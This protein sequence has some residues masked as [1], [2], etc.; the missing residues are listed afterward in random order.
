MRGHVLVAPAPAISGGTKKPPGSLAAFSGILVDL[1]QIDRKPS[2]ASG[3][4]K[5]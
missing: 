5:P 2:S 3:F 4:G 1:S